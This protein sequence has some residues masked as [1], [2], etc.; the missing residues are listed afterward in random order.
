[1]VLRAERAEG[2]R[3][4]GRRSVAARRGRAWGSSGGCSGTRVDP[5]DEAVAAGSSDADN[6]ADRPMSDVSRAIVT[7]LARIDCTHDAQ[8]H[9]K[10]T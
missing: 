2:R 1:M 10:R 6:K 9:G 5:R 4:L 8:M 7:R 3:P